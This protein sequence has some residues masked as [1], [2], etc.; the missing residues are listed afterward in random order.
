[1]K[2]DNRL[3]R[4]KMWWTPLDIGMKAAAIVGACALFTVMFS[5]GVLAYIIL[6]QTSSVSVEKAIAFSKENACHAQQIRETQGE[7]IEYHLRAIRRDCQAEA[8]KQLIMKAIP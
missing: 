3:T 2:A 1:M 7:I 8:R 6:Y 4:F 5:F